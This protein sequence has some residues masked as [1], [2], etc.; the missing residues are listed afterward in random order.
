[1]RFASARLVHIILASLWAVAAA[2]SMASAADPDADVAGQSCSP[3]TAAADVAASPPAGSCTPEASMSPAPAAVVTITAGDVWFKPKELTISSDGATT[4][5]LEDKGVV[6]HNFTVDELGILTVAQP[7]RSSETT[8]VDP[9]PGVYQFYCSV[10][11][12]RDAGM[13]GTLTVLPPTDEPT[14]EVAAGASPS[15]TVIA[16]ADPA[17]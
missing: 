5:R 11:G 13:V 9:P 4:I 12:H 14:D 3:A 16:S 2:G 7:G 10:S 8:I 17:A 1:V 6:V 15:P